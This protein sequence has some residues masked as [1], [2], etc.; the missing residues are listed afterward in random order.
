M[1]S[2]QSKASYRISYMIDRQASSPTI[3]GSCDLDRLSLDIGRTVRGVGIGGRSSSD[4]VGFFGSVFPGVGSFSVSVTKREDELV[5]RSSSPEDHDEEDG[6][7]VN[8]TNG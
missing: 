2:K 4:T 3:V 8:I 6:L 7:D 5:E 1:H